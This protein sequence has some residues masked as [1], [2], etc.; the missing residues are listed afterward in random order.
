M[1][2]VLATERVPANPSSWTLRDEAAMRFGVA[3]L[4]QGWRR[5]DGQRT[6]DADRARWAYE[7]ADEMLKARERAA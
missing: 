3:M 7:F 4:R 1:N 2:A 5:D 6:T